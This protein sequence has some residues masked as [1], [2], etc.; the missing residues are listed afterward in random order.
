[1][2]AL[3]CSYNVRRILN[4]DPAPSVQISVHPISAEG[5]LLLR[6]LVG[7]DD[8][9]IRDGVRALLVERLEA[10]HLVAERRRLLGWTSYQIADQLVLDR[11][12]AS[13]RRWETFPTTSARGQA[14]Q[15]FHS[16]A[17]QWY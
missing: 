11:L 1:V 5:I 15:R 7:C 6:P 2:D 14:L 16:Y 9:M 3:V 10:A 8:E 13:A 12:R 4:G 17:Y